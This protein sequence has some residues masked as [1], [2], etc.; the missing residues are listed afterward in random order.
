MNDEKQFPVLFGHGFFREEC[1][2]EGVPE[3]VPWAMLEPHEKQ[4]GINHGQSLQR[5][6][7]RGGL[8]VCEMV[9]VLEDRGWRKMS[10]K[11]AMH[12]LRWFLQAHARGKEQG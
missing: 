12:R 11:E 5:L 6:A 4:A 2:R 1:E 10:V 3:F 8:S 9:A 7:E